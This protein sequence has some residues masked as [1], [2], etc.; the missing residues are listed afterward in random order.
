VKVVGA[1]HEKNHTTQIL[2]HHPQIWKNWSF[3]HLLWK[4]QG[5]ICSYNNK[6]WRDVLKSSLI[7]YPQPRVI[8]TPVQFEPGNSG[9]EPWSYVQFQN[10]NQTRIETLEILILV[11][12]LGSKLKPLFPFLFFQNLKIKI[13]FF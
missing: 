3:L 12:M 1:N 9:T 7:L 8:M 10:R 6:I 5:N 2:Q 4:F 11:L 13:Y